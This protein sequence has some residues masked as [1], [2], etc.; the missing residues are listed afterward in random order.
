MIQRTDDIM[1]SQKVL[2]Q[3]MKMALERPTPAQE[4]KEELARM[5]EADINPYIKL[6]HEW[7]KNKEVCFPNPLL[8]FE[9]AKIPRENS[10]F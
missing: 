4:L 9:S 2:I 8:C 1:F 6:M 7:K 5:T 10:L 3:Q